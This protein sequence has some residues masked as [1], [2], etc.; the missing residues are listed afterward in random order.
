MGLKAL[1]ESRRVNAS[2]EHVKKN[3][4]VKVLT[5]RNRGKVSRV[6]EVKAGEGKV[7]VEGVAMVKHHQKPN[8]PRGVQ[9]GIIDKE[10]YINASN[11]MVVCPSCGK[12]TRVAHQEL[13]DGRHARACKKCGATIDRR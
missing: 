8:Q 11:V 4:R 13:Q 9:G 5:G 2:V 10:S 12:P 6:L 1:K 3:D 7:L